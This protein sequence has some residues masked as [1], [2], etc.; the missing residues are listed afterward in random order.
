MLSSFPPQTQ[1]IQSYAGPLAAALGHLGPLT[2]IGFRNMYPPLLFPGVQHA[3]DPTWPAPAAPGLDLRLV[4]RWYHPAGW[5]WHAHRTACDV[6]H[7]QWWSLPLFPV[8]AIFVRTMRRR[9]VPIVL[10]LHN[11]APH[12]PAPR[13]EHATAWL[14]RHADHIFV[15]GRVNREQAIARYAVPPNRVESIRFGIAG[16]DTAATPGDAAAS[17]ERLGLPQGVPLLLFFGIIR[18]YK[19]L[20]DLIEAFAR[21]STRHPEAHLVIAGK[22]WEPWQPYAD[23]IRAHGLDRRVITRLDYIPQAEVAHYYCACD[24]AALPYTHFDAQS[25][26]GMHS[27]AHNLPTVLSQTGALPEWVDNDPQ[28]LTPPG[29]PAALAERLDAILQD[30]KAACAAFRQVADRVRIE[31]SWQ[32]VAAVHHDCYARLARGTYPATRF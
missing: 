7:A 2:A 24:A 8:T 1:G 27:L 12:E 11:V 20:H 29:N 31:A 28:W 17:R 25:A 5:W 15:H 6:F 23:R 22:P 26:V 10:T 14:C 32:R 18:T 4:L 21:V 30:R 9:G 19:G 13:F 3:F 16:P